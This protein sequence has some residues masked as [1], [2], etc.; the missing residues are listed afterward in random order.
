MFEEKSGPPSGNLWCARGV[1]WIL[2]ALVINPLGTHVAIRCESTREERAEKSSHDKE[3][4]KAPIVPPGR[5][6]KSLATY[7]TP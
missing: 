4:C 7:V 1:K 5:G 2:T 6:E 3:K